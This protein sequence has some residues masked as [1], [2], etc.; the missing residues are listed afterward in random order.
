MDSMIV[1]GSI[2]FLSV[3]PEDCALQLTSD[4]LLRAYALGVFPMAESQSSPDLVWCD[5]DERGVLPI[6][7]CHV[8]KRLRKTLRQQPYDVTVDQ[9]FAGVISACAASTPRRPNTWINESIQC[10][11]QRLFDQGFAHS[12]ECWQDNRLQG[13]LYGVAIGGAFFGESMFA[14]AAEADKIALVHLVAGLKM[15]GFI[16]LDTQFVTP[17]LARFGVRSISRDAYHRWLQRAL[18]V[19]TAFPE[20]ISKRDVERLIQ[21]SSHMS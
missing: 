13:G 15:S 8:S 1:P 7:A 10:Q 12:I 6:D 3:W 14:R 9:D 21:S 2:A 20:D 19:K 4:V 18:L 5:P 11:T 16:L 17:H